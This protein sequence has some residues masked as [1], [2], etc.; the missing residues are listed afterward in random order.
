MSEIRVDI[1]ALKKAPAV[2]R[3]YK[4]ELEQELARELLAAVKSNFS[5]FRNPTGYY[6]SRVSIERNSVTDNGVVYG[7]WLEKG[8][9]GFKGYHSFEKAA[10]DVNK[11]A[12]QIAEKLLSNK[13]IGRLN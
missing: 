2:M 5:V 9:P 1:P 4:E 3:A 8:G 12:D 7:S 10:A 6:E 11:R 13:Y